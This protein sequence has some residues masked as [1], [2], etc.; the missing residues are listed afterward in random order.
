M[1]WLRKLLFNTNYSI[2]NY[3]FICIQSNSSKYCYLIPII[4]FR[5]IVKKF[6]VLLFNTNNSTQHYSFV[7][8]QISGSRYC[9]VAVITHLNINHLFT[10]LNDRTVLFIRNQFS[11]VALSL[12]VKQFQLLID[13]T[14]SGSTNL[15]QSEPGGNGN[16]G[17]LRIFLT[18]RLFSVI[19][20]TLIW[21]IL[22]YLPTLPHGQDM[23]QGQFLS[24]V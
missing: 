10:Q 8:P 19:I 6:Q 21:G 9:D 12:N 5:H 18:I 14:R 23:T 11:V 17:V 4:K 15:G 1:K 16:G 20:R 7:C 3:S 22:P 13:K 2:Q 24:G